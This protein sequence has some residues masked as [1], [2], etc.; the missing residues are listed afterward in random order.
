VRRR[1]YNN[2]LK[3]AREAARKAAGEGAQGAVGKQDEGKDG[4]EPKLKTFS[5]PRL[6]RLEKLLRSVVEAGFFSISFTRQDDSE[7]VQA[8]AIQLG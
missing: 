6:Q 3:A 1:D 7:D 5:S 8:F 2:A 4:P